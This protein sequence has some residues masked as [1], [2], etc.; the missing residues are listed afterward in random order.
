M[1]RAA[2][3][4]GITSASEL[5]RYCQEG[6]DVE[7]SGELSHDQLAMLALETDHVLPTDQLRTLILEARML[8]DSTVRVSRQGDEQFQELS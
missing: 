8:C 3:C 5:V 6:D 4:P 2:M 7:D 1:P